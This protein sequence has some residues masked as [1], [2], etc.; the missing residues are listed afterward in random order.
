MLLAA[1]LR[2][3]PAGPITTQLRVARIGRS[4]DKPRRSLTVPLSLS[5]IKIV[6]VYIWNKIPERWM[7][8][9]QERNC[10]PAQSVLLRAGTTAI[11][12][13]T[14]TE[15]AGKKVLEARVVDVPP[16]VFL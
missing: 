14:T 9:W 8:D 11:A 5:S 16:S 3:C 12:R 13:F 4:V 7:A 1:R 15:I 2:S 6:I 10:R